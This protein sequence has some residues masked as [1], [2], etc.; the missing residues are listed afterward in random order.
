MSTTILFQGDSITD[1]GRATCGGAG[2][3]NWGAGPGYPGMIGAKLWAKYPERDYKVI[4]TG[5]SGNRIVDLYARWRIDTLNRE[6]DI[7]SILIGVNDSLHELGSKNGVD[8]PRYERIYRELLQWTLDA[9]PGIKIILIEPFLG[10]NNPDLLCLE[11]EVEQRR[12][13][14]R[15][16][17]DEFK[18]VFLPT[19]KMFEEATKRAPWSYWSADAVHPTPAGHQLLTDAWLKAMDL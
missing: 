13:V 7:L 19:Q 17:A 10:N 8:V 3:T 2:F 4:N 11:P 18:T 9:R 12:Q 5:I 15:K 14:V 16:L 1:C 6:P